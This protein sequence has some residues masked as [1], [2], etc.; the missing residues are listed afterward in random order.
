MDSFF[1]QK[2]EKIPLTLKYVYQSLYNIAH[3]KG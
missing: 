1:I 3:T 2:K